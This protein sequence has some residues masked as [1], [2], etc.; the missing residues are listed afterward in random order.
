[1]NDQLVWDQGVK[2]IF[3]LLG[4]LT[5]DRKMEL[6]A[7]LHDFRSCKEIIAAISQSV[8]SESI[9]EKCAG[10]CCMNGKYRT[11]VFD[12]ISIIESG[13]TFQPDFTRKPLCPYSSSAGC[14][15]SPRFRPADCILFVCDEIDRQLHALAKTEFTSEEKKLRQ[16]LQAASRLLNIP[17][18]T[19]LLLWAEIL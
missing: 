15:A 4:S 13:I 1:M 2:R 11:N 10:Q 7:L 12:A 3:N 19:P 9:C 8:D 5:E 18:S 14:T 16:H 17:A 6:M